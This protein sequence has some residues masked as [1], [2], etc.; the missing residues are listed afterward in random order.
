MVFLSQVTLQ[1]HHVLFPRC[2]SV[3]NTRCACGVYS[4]KGNN[5]ILRKLFMI[6]VKIGLAEEQKVG[7][8][9]TQFQ[10]LGKD[11]YISTNF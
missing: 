4:F 8:D 9:C 7:N 1:T 6:L 5:Y 2:F 3:E 11:F 10:K